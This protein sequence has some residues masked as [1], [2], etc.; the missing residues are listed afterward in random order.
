MAI[1]KLLHLKEGKQMPSSSL[2]NCIN[3]IF[4]DAKTENG[5]WVG[6]NSGTTAE[7]VYQTM[8]DTKFLYEK[9]NGRQ[10][11]H[12]IISFEKGQ[13]D[14]ATAFSVMKEWCETYFGENYDYAFSIHN[15]R[16]HMHGHIVFNSV[17]RETGYKYR[18]ENGDWEKFIQPI[19]DRICEKY[20]L[21]K[22]TYEK[23]N[24]RK[25]Y[26]EHMAAIHGKTVWKDIIKKD[27][28]HA[29]SRSDSYEGVL[30]ILKNMDYMIREGESKKH[31]T[32]LA[33]HA[34]GAER[35]RRTY[36]LGA[37]YGVEEIKARVRFPKKESVY[38]NTPKLKTQRFINGTRSSWSRYQVRAVQRLYHAKN[39]HALNPYRVNQT[40]VRKDLLHIEQISRSCRYLIRHQITSPEE[41]QARKQ[42]LK[43]QE[44]V[45]RSR[46]GAWDP[47]E[48][49]AAARYRELK[50]EL[51]KLPFEDDGFEQ[52]QDEMEA[53]EAKYPNSI[54]LG[55][56]DMAKQEVLWIKEEKSIIRY[57]E[58]MQKETEMLKTIKTP[59]LK[60]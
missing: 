40:Q 33:L 24:I 5:L 54:L 16:D 26:A 59:R 6:G 7:E 38:P 13:T 45:L 12:F 57:L 56:G 1:T 18:Y 43:T 49:A 53:L 35:A 32:Y 36:N 39:Y 46:E 30:T 14:E 19:T 55:A 47:E 11:Y 52:I 22:L 58:K 48:K 34:P 25:S 51:R 2:K 23:S 60:K 21:P 3:Y 41:I 9:E 42:I 50:E 28:D 31:G 27:I 37:G 8:M 29:I 4:K 10:G 15:D 44:K 20:G 17:S